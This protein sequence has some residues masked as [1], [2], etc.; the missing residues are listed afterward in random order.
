MTDAEVEAWWKQNRDVHSPV[1][2]LDKAQRASLEKQADDVAELAGSAGW[3]FFAA[4]LQQQREFLALKLL[5]AKDAF[6]V[7]RLQGNIQ[8]LDEVLRWPKDFVD[9]SNEVLQPSKPKPQR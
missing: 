2:V 7:G 6:E 5:K 3:V 4:Q 1:A 9:A 8:V